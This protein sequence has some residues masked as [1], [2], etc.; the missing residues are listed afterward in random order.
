MSR[1]HRLGIRFGWI[2]CAGL[3]YSSL[4]IAQDM[5]DIFVQNSALRSYQTDYTKTG[6]YKAFA[7][8]PSGTW[9]WQGNVLKIE[10]A[11]LLALET[12]TRH[13]SENELPCVIVDLNGELIGPLSQEERVFVTH[14]ALAAYQGDY[15]NAEPYK[16]FAQSSDGAW[17]WQAD[18]TSL[19]RAIN[20]ALAA[21]DSHSSA[22]DP[23]CVI[24][25][26]NGELIEAG[27]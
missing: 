17:A 3:L 10:D 25:D 12:C 7:Q 1:W 6:G 22:D 5:S 8:S 14:A 4:V 16:A 11:V 26:R 15:Q 23:D 21:C 20:D 9:A 13:L 18:R 2:C 27:R 24:V 19:E